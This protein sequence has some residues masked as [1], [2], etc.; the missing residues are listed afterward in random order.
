MADNSSEKGTGLS[1][2]V[3]VLTKGSKTEWFQLVEK[4]LEGDGIKWLLTHTN[5][6]YA[7]IRDTSRKTEPDA[8]WTP[9]TAEED[10]TLIKWRNL[11]EKDIEDKRS[12][13]NFRLNIRFKISE[14]DKH[15]MDENVGIPAQYACLK[16]RYKQTTYNSGHSRIVAFTIWEMNVETSP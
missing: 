2:L 16:I 12:Q 14:A 9:Y 13:I 5:R 1:K 7:H 8:R 11:P 10:G 15:M 6:E 3:P 4:V